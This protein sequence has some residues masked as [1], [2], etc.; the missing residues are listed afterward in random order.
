MVAGLLL[1]LVDSG[2]YRAVI[3]TVYSLIV[4]TKY[5]SVACP[6]TFLCEQWAGDTLCLS[7][8]LFFFKDY[9]F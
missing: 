2:R 4:V 6:L 3:Y 1:W 7:F 9:F 8:L 5:M